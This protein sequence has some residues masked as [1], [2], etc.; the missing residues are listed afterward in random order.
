MPDCDIKLQ[1]IREQCALTGTKF[2]DV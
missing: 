1:R 2:T